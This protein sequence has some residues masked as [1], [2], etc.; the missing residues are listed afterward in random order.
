MKQKKF[1]PR[2]ILNQ[3][4]AGICGVARMTDKARVAHNGEIGN[5][6]KYGADS[7]QD[8]EVLSFL[9]ISANDFQEIAVQ[10]DDDVKLGAWILDKCERSSEEVSEFNNKL[11]SQEKRITPRQTYASR[12]RQLAGDDDPP[13][14]WW[15]AP[16]WWVI[17]KLFRR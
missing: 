3:D 11:K 10:I 13:F 9:D 7:K 15:M 4:I 2:G 1:R 16:G 12:R 5:Y 17:W 8:T 6:Y 14:P